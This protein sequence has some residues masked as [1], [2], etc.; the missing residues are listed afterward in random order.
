MA[1]LVEEVVTHPA[2]GIHVLVAGQPDREVRWV[3]AT[4]QADP[5]PY[6]RGG[7]IVLTDGL[8]LDSEQTAIDYVRRLRDIDIAAIGYGPLPG[9]FDVPTSLIDA[10]RVQDVCLFVMPPTLP[11]M[12]V[13]EIFVERLAQDREASLA[14]NV[15]RNMRLL[16]WHAPGV[17]PRACSMSCA[18][19]SHVRCGSV[20]R[21]AR[22]CATPAGHP[23]TPIATNLPAA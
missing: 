4:E 13:T 2:L 9:S 5:T 15:A 21:T 18:R 20:A 12:A 22:L 1:L 3:H 7:E 14:S 16:G 8:W 6:L 11:F 10:C 19:R 17:G 23:P